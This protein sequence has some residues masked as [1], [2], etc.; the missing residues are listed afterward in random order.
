MLVSGE[1]YFRQEEHRVP[2]S[3]DK[4]NCSAFCEQ[5]DAAVTGVEGNCRE[6]G[7]QCGDLVLANLAKLELRL[8]EFSSLYGIRLCLARTTFL[9]D[10]KSSFHVYI[11]RVG[12][13]SGTVAFSTYLLLICWLHLAAWGS[14]HTCSNSGSCQTKCLSISESCTLCLCGTN[15]S[16]TYVI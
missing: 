6:V 5:K 7:R 8:P 11:Q 2:R 12:V 16:C 1:Q 13:P 3:W 14:R 15:I 4:M 9:W 10:L